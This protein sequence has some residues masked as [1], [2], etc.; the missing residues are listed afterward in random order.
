MESISRDELPLEA[1]YE[2]LEPA[3]Q[4]NWPDADRQPIARVVALVFALD[5]A[6]ALHDPLG[7]TSLRWHRLKLTK[8][9]MLAYSM[10]AAQL[11]L[12]STNC[13]ACS[14]ESSGGC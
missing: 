12:A 11:T 5:T 10:S 14:N 13:G 6:E 8:M 7:L 4:K 3:L 1:C 9:M 2:Q